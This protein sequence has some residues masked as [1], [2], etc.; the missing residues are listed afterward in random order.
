MHKANLS[1]SNLICSDPELG[2]LDDVLAVSALD[3]SVDVSVELAHF[4]DLCLNLLA[5]GSIVPKVSSL[6]KE[7]STKSLMR[8]HENAV[9][10]RVAGGACILAKERHIPHKVT[11]LASLGSGGL[12]G[13]F[14]V[15]ASHV[16]NGTL[17]LNNVKDGSEA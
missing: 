8:V 16:L 9:L 4:V 15:D 2:L 17:N 13:G 11:V 1:P 6:A 3:N 7:V 12:F 14:V 10:V 5:S